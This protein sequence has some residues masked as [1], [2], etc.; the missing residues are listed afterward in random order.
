MG[1]ILVAKIFQRGQHRIRRRLAESAERSRLDLLGQLLQHIQVLHRAL[2]FRDFLQNLQQAL[3][4]N[5]A[6]RAFAA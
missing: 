3:G 5:S 4:T 6:R 1:D 2:T